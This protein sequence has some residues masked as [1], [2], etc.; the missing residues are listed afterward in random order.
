[1]KHSILKL[2]LACGILFSCSSEPEA[3]NEETSNPVN[4]SFNRQATGSSS[5]DLLSASIFNKMV[6]EVGYITGF[7]PTEKAMTNF[8]AFIENRAFK[9]EGVSFVENQVPASGKTSYTL[10]RGGGN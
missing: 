8:K 3:I 4:T 2:V 10:R 7:R 6:V 5:N 1:M 9:P